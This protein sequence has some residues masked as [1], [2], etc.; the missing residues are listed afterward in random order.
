MINRFIYEKSL[1]LERYIIKESLMEITEAMRK[2]KS[3]RGFKL[4]PVPKDTL[5]KILETAG[6]APSA[7]NT[8]P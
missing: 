2:R 1:F 4:D 8:Q 6:R 7:M 5:R 3:I